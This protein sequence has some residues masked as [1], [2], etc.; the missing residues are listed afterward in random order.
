MAL[1]SKALTVQDKD[2]GDKPAVINLISS[3]SLSLSKFT[4]VNYILPF[5][6]IKLLFALAFLLKL[7]GWKSTLV[8]V[9]ATVGTVPIHKWVV[10]NERAAKKRVTVARDKKT[11]VVSEALHALR[12]IKFSALES[13]W[14]ERIDLCRREELERLRENF[15][16]ANIRSVWKVA[17]PFLVAAVAVC[18]YAYTENNVSSSIIFTI[19][20]L[21]PHLQG[22]LGTLPVAFQDYFGSRVNA[23]RIEE[24]LKEPDL[25]KILDPSPDGNVTFQDACIAWPS[26]EQNDQKSVILPNRFILSDVNIK[27]PTGELSIIHGETG[28]G[29]SLLL[30]AIIGEVDL[31]RGQVES[32]ASK[33]PVAFVSQT[34]WLQNATVKENI[35]F[36]SSFEEVR[37]LKVL[38]AC[39][40]ETDLAAL[41]LGDQTYIG[42][43]GVKLSGGQRARVALARAL[44]SQARLIVLDDIFAAL[45]SHVSR[46]I[47]GALTG[48]LCQGRTRILATHQVSLCSPTAKYIVEIHNKTTRARTIDSNELKPYQPEPVDTGLDESKKNTPKPI[49][50][51]PRG[52]VPKAGTDLDA[53]KRFFADAGGLGFVSIFVIGLVVKQIVVASTTRALGRINSARIGIK[54]DDLY[55]SKGSSTHNYL[56]IYLLGSLSAV[57]MEFLFNFHMYSGSLRASKALFRRMTAKVIRMPL[58]WLDSTPIGDMLKRFNADM[59]LVDDFLLEAVS[60][61]SD[62]FVKLMIVMCIGMYNSIYTS[63]L[64]MGLLYWCFQVA[65]SYNQARRTIKIGESDSNADILEY[66]TT[67]MSGVSTIRAFGATDQ[68]MD[69]M[70]RRVDNLS[71]VRRHFWIFNRWLG[72]QMSFA[73]ILFTTGTGIILLSTTSMLDASLMGVA[74]TFSMGFSKASFDAANSFGMLERYTG[75]ASN[76]VAYTEL[77]TERQGGI[78]VTPD[79]PPRGKIEVKELN[80]RYSPDLPLV[81]K[82][83]SFSVNPGQRIGIVGRTGAGKSSLTLALLRFMDAQ[84][85][86]IYIDGIDISTIKLQSLRSKVGFIPQD[87]VLFSGTIQSN[88]DYFNEFPRNKLNGALQRVKLLTEKGEE[89]SGSFSLESKV[90]AGGTNMSQGQRQLLCLARIL[91]RDQKIVILDEA[92]SSVD[93]QTDFLIQDTIRNELNRTL[94]VVAHRLRTIA[95]FDKVI[96]IHEGQIGEAG[97]PAELLRAKELFYNLVRESED[98]EFVINTALQ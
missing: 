11:K 10:K 55:N 82:N 30:S 46:Q 67:S 58:L 88:L 53:F 81:L 26:E 73:G 94:I 23:K 95:S 76:I 1:Y 38:R 25:K 39:A 45:D 63:C 77:A 16:A 8:A 93:D 52:K 92:T 9:I 64:T 75:Y 79:W 42:L 50:S 27:F 19:I 5:S 29:K 71:T 32:P 37:Y 85:G 21:L 66:F 70:H 15:I 72:L 80:V 48:E 12:H 84:S 74:L 6:F 61:T 44:Y 7:L 3:D 36:G 31:L 49:R 41:K 78:E 65:K 28:S 60:G 51:T 89:E 96:V 13:Q 40:L 87:P 86:S 20:E 98:R 59:R 2:T 22:T 57:V 91:V 83:V 54:P 35:L 18:S 33:Q 14:E 24:F 97:T 56:Y 43:R 90:T 17:S 69:Q 47:M 4:A 62:S 34:P 68:F